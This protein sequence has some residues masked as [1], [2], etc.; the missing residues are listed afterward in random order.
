M[1]LFEDFFDD[2]I[3]DVE[4]IDINDQQ[5]HSVYFS[6]GLDKQRYYINVEEL[7][8]YPYMNT[9]FKIYNIFNESDY[10]DTAEID[11]NHIK[12]DDYNN[13][14]FVDIKLKE[15]TYIIDWNDAYKDLYK[16]RKYYD[17][18]IDTMSIKIIFK[19]DFKF[20]D[21]LTFEDFCG[22]IRSFKQPLERVHNANIQFT[23]FEAMNNTMYVGASLSHTTLKT[24]YETL[25][26][27]GDKIHSSNEIRDSYDTYAINSFD[28]ERF[29]DYA[30]EQCR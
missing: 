23:F 24:T 14:T 1:I 30:C 12:L 11:F 5:L 3:T 26:P 9:I 8:N 18:D 10:V 25:F 20:N 4:S 7:Y 17:N 21:N 27:Y 16:V 13:S 29:L 22:F 28:F 6:F 2:N 19:I 15:N